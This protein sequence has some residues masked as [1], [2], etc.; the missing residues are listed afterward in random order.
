MVQNIKKGILVSFLLSC[1]F[2][3]DGIFSQKINQLNT[4]NQRTGVWKK[5]HSNKRIRYVGQFKNG[6]EIGTFKFYDITTSKH[7]VA[8]KEYSTKSDSISVKFYTLNGKLRSVGKMIDKKRVGAW[9]YF[10]E[11][12]KRF[13]E[14]FYTDGKLEGV[15]KNYY[16]NGK[17]TEHITYK[18]GLKHGIAKL[19]SDE[20]ILLE[21][22]NYEKG[23]ENGLA[24]YYDLKGAIKEKGVYKNGKR[25]GKWDFY[26]DGETVSRKEKMNQKKYIKKKN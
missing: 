24:I 22:V 21:E 11:N 9:L 2:S 14:E 1:F 13:S 26:L 6:K 3:A 5:Y 19:Y 4:K 12:G 17:I 15:V 7:P 10:Y 8:I 25:F 20:G 23:K 18:N 16:K